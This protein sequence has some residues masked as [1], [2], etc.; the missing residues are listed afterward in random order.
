MIDGDIKFCPFCG[1]KDDID[2]NQWKRSDGKTGPGCGRCGSN[3]EDLETW[4]TR[5]IED[6]LRTQLQ[7]ANERIQRL[8][9]A[10]KALRVMNANEMENGKP[11]WVIPCESYEPLKTELEK[12]T[13]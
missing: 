13:P 7:A 6:A 4:N 2:Q 1:C 8:I 11:F 10:A 3:A 5:P 12:E 9:T